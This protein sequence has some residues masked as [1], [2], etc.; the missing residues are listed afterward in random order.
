MEGWN[1]EIRDIHTQVT[2]IPPRALIRDNTSE[3]QAVVETRIVRLIEPLK[4]RRRM[5]LATKEVNQLSQDLDNEIVSSLS[6]S[7]SFPPIA[8]LLQ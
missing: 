6:F 1:K 2:A 4:E 8:G 5:L 7:L 3:K